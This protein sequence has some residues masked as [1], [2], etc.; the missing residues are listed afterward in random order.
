MD[1]A[2]AWAAGRSFVEVCNMTDFF[3][4]NIIRSLRRLEEL[5]R[6]SGTAAGAIG[7]VELKDKFELGATKLRRGIVFAASLYV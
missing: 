1:V 4:G 7:N 5:L 6:Q 2:F 3:E